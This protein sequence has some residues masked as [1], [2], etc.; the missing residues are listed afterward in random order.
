M[1]E[2]RRDRH[3]PVV[4]LVGEAPHDPNLLDAPPVIDHNRLTPD[5]D[6]ETQPVI[7]HIPLWIIEA[8]L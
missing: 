8:I 3:T 7:R 2:I 6:K 5:E 1:V 4:P